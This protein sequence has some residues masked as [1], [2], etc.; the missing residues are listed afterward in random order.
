[1]C[2]D[3]SSY[4][5]SDLPCHSIPQEPGSFCIGNCWAARNCVKH[6]AAEPLL[7]HVTGVDITVTLRTDVLQGARADSQ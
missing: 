2:V 7:A 6:T 5:Q 3:D 1:M 4:V